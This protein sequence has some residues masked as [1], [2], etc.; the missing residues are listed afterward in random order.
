[1]SQIWD[2]P[3]LTHRKMLIKIIIYIYGKFNFKLEILSS[4]WTKSYNFHTWHVF[5]FLFTFKLQL[6]FMNLKVV[7]S[8]NK[9]G[10]KIV[11]II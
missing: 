2:L 10:S 9:G 1:M 7:S 6:C 4:P 3:L 11:P 8:E 5:P